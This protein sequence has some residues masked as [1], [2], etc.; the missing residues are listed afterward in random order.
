MEVNNLKNKYVIIIIIGILLSLLSINLFSDETLI[1]IANDPNMNYDKPEVKI[2]PYGTIYV[3]YQA[4]NIS[5][6]RSDIFL[7]KYENGKVSFVK[8][9]SN[10]SGYSYEPEVDIRGN[11]D[12]HLAWCDEIGTSHTIKYRYFNG[13]T[14]SN[15]QTFGRVTGTMIEDLRIAV[16]NSGNVFVVFMHF[17]ARRSQF[18]SKYGNTISFQNF[19]I[20][21][22]NKHPDVVVNNDYIHV[23]SQYNSG[24]YNVAY[25]RRPNRS[26]SNWDRWISVHGGGL[27][28]RPRL[29][30]DSSGVPHV[31]YWEGID[32]NRTLYYEYKS[33]S[34]FVGRKSMFGT[35]S[36]QTYHFCDINAANSSNILVS[37]QKG[38]WTSGT[39]IYYN[40]KVNGVWS[41][42]T[43]LKKS[44][45]KRPAKVS[46]DLDSANLKGVIAFCAT[47]DVVYLDLL[48]TTGEIVP[49]APVALFTLTPSRGNIPLNVSFD[50]TT[51]YSDSGTIVSW[52]WRFGDGGTATG[53]T[54]SHTYSRSGFF[55]AT[56][57][58]TDTQGKTGTSSK[59]IEAIKINTP[60]LA[61]FTYA[62]RSGLY[63]LYV[64]VNPARSDDTDGHI[65]SYK[66]TFGDG[67][68]IKKT[69]KAPFTHKYSK[70]GNYTI[71][72][73]VTDNQNGS[74]SY[75]QSVF[76]YG[77][78]APVSVKSEIIENRTLFTIEYV[79]NITWRP[80]PS[81]KERGVNIV[82]Y[83]IMKK[84]KEESNYTL[85]H[86]VAGS[87][88]EHVDRIGGVIIEYDYKIIAVDED[89]RESK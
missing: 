27:V 83:K 47:N 21:G 19:P 42:F 46:N 43:L 86:E 81:N 55:I 32:P 61:F 39:A 26:G 7:S 69:N 52:D 18:I 23:S 88:T 11:G 74:N 64:T 59:T 2:G 77:V 25:L 53:Q 62:P 9:I 14:W 73:R 84:R 22:T 8:N 5:S 63:P 35:A 76:V 44:V 33:G 24:S 6:G 54:A 51:S 56:L 20:S 57:T 71:G 75:S 38:G 87:V 4:D 41:G 36:P 66:W 45:G 13:S 16:D 31:V 28:Q 29:D 40:W 89:G 68:S 79:S 12:I 48:S 72:L 3:A 34:S 82:K 80:N 10:S 85:F 50:A 67:S 1:T 65:V 37:M 78:E 60:P 58:I 17:P 15:V 70:I 30:I 49:G